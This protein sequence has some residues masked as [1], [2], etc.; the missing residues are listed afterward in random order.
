M[1]LVLVMQPSAPVIARWFLFG[2]QPSVCVNSV[3]V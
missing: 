2:L 1:L 3:N